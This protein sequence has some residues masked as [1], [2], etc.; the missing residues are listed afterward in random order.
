MFIFRNHLVVPL[1]TTKCIHQQH[2]KVALRQRQRQHFQT[3]Q[4]EN[5]TAK[6]HI[7]ELIE[8]MQCLSK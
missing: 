1:K 6:Q 4:I 7:G 5:T 3:D 8:S 2:M